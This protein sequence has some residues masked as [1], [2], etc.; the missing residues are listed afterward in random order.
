[1]KT[2]LPLLMIISSTILSTQAQVEPSGTPGATAPPGG[3]PGLSPPLGATYSIVARAANHRIWQGVVA[4]TDALG[5]V[6]YLTNSYTELAAGMYYMDTQSGQWTESQELV[7]SFPG[8]AIARHGQH[9]VMFA[10]DLATAGAIDMQ[11]PDGKRLV[12]HIIG[13][14]Y[15]DTSTGTNV[16][17]AEVTNC[18]GRILPPNQV[19]YESAFSELNASVRYTYT[20]DGF[21]QDVILLEAPPAPEE[22]G[23]NPA[24]TRL[25]VLTEFVNPPQPATQTRVLTQSDGTEAVDETLD[26]GVMQVGSGRAF[27]LGPSGAGPGITVSKQWLKLEGRDFLVEEIPVPALLKAIESLPKN[28]GASLKSRGRTVQLAQGRAAL[29]LVPSSLTTSAL[30]SL[31]APK[32]AKADTNLMHLAKARLPERGLL[33]DYYFTMISTNSFTFQSDTT[34]YVSGNVSLS[35]TTVCEGGTVIKFTNSPTAK[36]SMS[37]P[38]VCKAGQ[39]RPIIMTSKN[40]NTVGLSISGSTGSPTNYNGATYLEDNNSQTNTYQYL[41]LSYAGIGLSAAIFSNGVW[42]CQFVKC[43]TAVNASGSGTVALHNVLMTQCTNGVI[44]TGTLSAEHLTADQCV[45]LLA[46]TGSSG[47]L[48]NSLLTAVTAV[49]NMSLYNSAQLSSGS[50]VY[51]AVGA[52]SYYLA[53]GSTNRNAG[54]RN[55]STQLL[56]DLKLRTTYPPIVLTNRITTDTTLT[57]QAQ[58]DTDVPDLGYSYDPLDY[59][60]SGLQLTNALVLTNGVALGAYGSCDGIISYGNSVTHGTIVSQGLTDRLNYIVHYNTVQEQTTTNWAALYSASTVNLCSPYAGAQFSFTGWSIPGALRAHFLTAGNSLTIWFKNC[61]FS[62]GTISVAESSVAL[63]NCLFERVTVS[64]NDDEDI[65]HW[66]LQNNLFRGG[67][68]SYRMN[69]FPNGTRGLAYDNVFDRTTIS[70]GNGTFTN[71]YNAYITNCSKLSSS[72]GNDRILTNSPVYQTSYLGRYYYPTN[73]G[74]LSTLINMGSRYATNVG[75]Y[76]FTTT[77]NQV[78]EGGTIVDIGFHY[79]AVDPSTG[80]PYDTDGDGVPDYLE[81]AN[82]NGVATDDPTSWLIYNSPNAL[83]GGNGLQ[84]F[85]PLK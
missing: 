82:G 9:Q 43:G 51:Q 40:D 30:W 21:E 37:G 64:F 46:G 22:Y 75:L 55:I 2:L 65:G 76:H 10:N 19:I 66:Y 28:Q 47:V 24:T 48:T 41:R 84:V 79:V 29:P 53:D 69:Y 31:P 25:G 6:S 83:T 81:D 17:I 8:G 1:M 23:L 44:T 32:A 18:I 59:V 12:S 11:T 54:T 3:I 73:D 35:G 52:A 50:G 7:E 78:K 62:G 5:R 60:V 67:S 39:Y 33:L 45:T 57:P 61:Q 26:F 15:F 80:Q 72:Q 85:T 49:T 36:L 74:M 56:S 38:L 68:L 63:T 27:L 70:S 14:S 71:G 4:S 42:H 34:Y 16:L 13:L 20:R 77:T 58:R